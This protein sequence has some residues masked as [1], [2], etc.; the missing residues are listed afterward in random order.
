MD[1]N[2]E[3]EFSRFERIL[4][5]FAIVAFQISV[6]F[7]ANANEHYV[8][9]LFMLITTFGSIGLTVKIIFYFTLASNIAK[10]IKKN[11]KQN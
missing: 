7:W 6:F 5:V 8:L 9:A 4:F 3:P 11:S 2:N 1:S 10:Q